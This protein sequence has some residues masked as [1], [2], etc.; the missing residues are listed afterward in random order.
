MPLWFTDKESHWAFDS[1]SWGQSM[2]HYQEPLTLYS[3]LRWSLNCLFTTT[4]STCSCEVIHLGM[5]TRFL[6]MELPA[7][8]AFTSGA[9]H[10]LHT[11]KTNIPS[12]IRSTPGLLFHTT[13]NQS[14]VSSLVTQPLGWH[15]TIS[16]LGSCSLGIVLQFRI[17]QAATW[18][19]QLIQGSSNMTGTDFCVNKPHCAAVVRPWESEATT[20][21]LPH[22][23]VRTCS[24]LSGSC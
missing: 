9:K 10:P 22:A 21:T 18:Y 5:T 2:V 19:H 1:S 14:F 13:N 15:M 24:V 7:T 20:S 23:R 11:T 4:S 8:V 3:C 6:F 17:T 12:F 16:P